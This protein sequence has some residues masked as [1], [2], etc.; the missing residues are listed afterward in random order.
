LGNG[1]AARLAARSRLCPIPASTSIRPCIDHPPRCSRH[2]DTALAV[3]MQTRSRGL[4]HGAPTAAGKKDSYEESKMTVRS[5][6]VVLSVISGI[7]MA[8]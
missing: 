8:A 5:T 4:R 3:T 1:G 6:R 7:T 2:P